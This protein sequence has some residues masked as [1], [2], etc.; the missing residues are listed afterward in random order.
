LPFQT[1]D[2]VCELFTGA[3]S[4]TITLGGAKPTCR[5][6]SSKYTA[7]D[8]FWGTA[9]AVAS[10][11]ISVGKFTYN[12]TTI[13][14]TEV[15]YSSNSDT[16]VSFSLGGA[17]EVY[18][19]IPAYVLDH[20]NLVEEVLASG[21]T[22]DLGSIKGL[23]IELQG[24]TNPSS[25]GTFKN[26][27]R[28]VRYTGAGLT[29]TN[30]ATLVCP[31]AANLPLA[32][33]QIFYAVSD[34]SSPP[35]WRILWRVDPALAPFDR[36]APGAIGGTT[37][38]AGSF[39]TLGAT[40]AGTFNGDVTI[41]KTSPSFFLNK[42]ATSGADNLLVGA[43]N[44]SNLWLF[45][46]GNNANMAGANAGA[47]F[48]INRYSDAG[49]FLAKAFSIN[50]ASGAVSVTAA[51]SKGSGTFLIDHPLDPKNKDLYHGFVEA[52]RYDLIYRGKVQLVKG[53]ATVEIDPAS[54]MTPGTFAA[55]TQNA[56]VVAL[57]NLS[58]FARVKSSAV[59]GGGFKITCEDITS[60]DT[61]HWVVIAERADAFIKNNEGAHTDKQGRMVPEQNK[62]ADDRGSARHWQELGHP[63]PKKFLDMEARTQA[64]H[65]A[66]IAAAAAEAE[67]AAEKPAKPQA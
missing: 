42:T 36:R 22:T 46:L 47:D 56:E 4:T 2:N 53:V 38:A 10:G 9:H 62:V 45:D 23:C 39:T 11:E 3:G 35:I 54:N 66:R 52:P 13:T 27:Q 59:V 5:A 65:E 26:K 49:S 41:T 28:I 25:F 30:G 43:V 64:A 51:L 57:N 67:A 40:G 20:L 63:K 32:T 34:N 33:G 19:D 55:L 60:S 14:Q 1:H 50:R 7:G 8:T 17:C 29:I 16:A 61:I 58:G 21:A 15:K 31:G 48:D 24:T 6:F 18:N 44:G 12:G 37:P